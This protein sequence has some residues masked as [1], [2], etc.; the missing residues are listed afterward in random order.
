MARI[1]ATAR[2]AIRMTSDNVLDKGVT[3]LDP[4]ESTMSEL[5]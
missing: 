2:M 4:A 3:S 1:A 5:R